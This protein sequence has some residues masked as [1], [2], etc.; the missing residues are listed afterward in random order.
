MTGTIADERTNEQRTNHV[1]VIQ[2]LLPLHNTFQDMTDIGRTKTTKKNTVSEIQKTP[3]HTADQTRV[4]TRTIAD[5]RRTESVQV[6]A[7][8]KNTFLLDS[9]HRPTPDP[10]PP[11]LRGQ[12]SESWDALVVFDSVVVKTALIQTKSA[13]IQTKS[14]L[15][16]TKTA[17]IQTKTALIQTQDRTNPDQD[18]IN[19]DQDRTNPDQDRTNPDQDRTNP[20][21]DRTNPDQDRTN[22]DQDHTNPD[23]DHTNPDQDHITPHYQDQKI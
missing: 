21:Q 10:D 5:E 7:F 9:F 12:R 19:P 11:E 1:Q 13:L 2:T 8:G 6:Q 20:D 15:I 17:L 18:R 3:E 22:P 4:M 16:Q 14:A 23:Q